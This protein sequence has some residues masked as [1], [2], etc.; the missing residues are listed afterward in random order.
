MSV[1]R[2][3]SRDFRDHKKGT[4]LQSKI[5]MGADLKEVSGMQDV[6]GEI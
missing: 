6:E 5:I 4:H 3:A 1:Q 2:I